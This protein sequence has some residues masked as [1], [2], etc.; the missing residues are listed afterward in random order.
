[1]LISHFLDNPP[2]FH[3]PPWEWSLLVLHLHRFANM[4]FSEW[5]AV[6]VVM[7]LIQQVSLC[8]SL[9]S[10]ISLQ[11]LS[12]WYFSRSM[13]RWS[14]ITR[15]YSISAVDKPRSWWGVFL[16]VIIACT[17]RSWRKRP[18]PSAHYPQSN[19]R[20]E[21]A[22]KTAKRTLIS[23]SAFFSLFLQLVQLGHCSE[24]NAL[25]TFAFLRPNPPRMTCISVNQTLVFH[26]KISPSG[27]RMCRTNSVGPRI[28]L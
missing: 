4:K 24:D 21:L 5:V 19:G 27:H 1:M 26:P 10:L 17:A 12:I 23:Q 16:W 7:L 15:P 22:V 8:L 18:Y 6:Y 3:P 11:R 20:A 28:Q 9:N 13:G 14:L 25:M 2:C